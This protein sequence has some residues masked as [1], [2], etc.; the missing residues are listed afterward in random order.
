MFDLTTTTILSLVVP[1]IVAPLACLAFVRV[2]ARAEAARHTARKAVP[3]APNARIVLESPAA[4]LTAERVPER[5]V[6]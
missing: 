5:N 6:A 4:P 2:I 3:A 1:T